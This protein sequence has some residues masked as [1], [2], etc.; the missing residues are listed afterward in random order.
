[1]IKSK[2][3]ELKDEKYK[4]FSSSLLPGIDNIIGVRFPILRKLSKNLTL[5]ELSD[6]TFEEIMLQGM[7]IGHMKDFSKLKEELLVFLPKINNWSICDSFVSSL[8]LT[9]TK[10]QEMFQVLKSL[11]DS[12]LEYTRRFILVMLLHYY[13]DDEYLKE[14][15]QLA[16]EIKKDEYYVKMAYA[17]FIGEVYFKDK[18]LSKKLIDKEE[19]EWIKKKSFSK[20]KESKKHKNKG[21]VVL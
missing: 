20:I 4:E 21:E 5:D 2:L 13:L 18:D 15:A 9:K 19:D 16:K 8:T 3:L 12:N 14:A 6:D 7:V 1:M 10:K 17:W 11:K